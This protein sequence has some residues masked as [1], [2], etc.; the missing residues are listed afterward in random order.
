MLDWEQ[1]LSVSVTL[2]WDQSQ[3]FC[4]CYCH[5]VTGSGLYQ[6]YFGSGTKLTVEPSKFV[7]FLLSPE[8][9]CWSH[10]CSHF[11]VVWMFFSK[12]Q[13]WVSM[14]GNM[15]IYYLNRPNQEY[16]NCDSNLFLLK[17]WSLGSWTNSQLLTWDKSCL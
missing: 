17:E 7:L 1:Q 13:I 14:N 4:S 10:V 16:S 8:H 15:L 9:W 5:S 3:C 6:I 2:S 11:N 12:P